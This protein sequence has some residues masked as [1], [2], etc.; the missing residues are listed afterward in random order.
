[1]FHKIKSIIYNAHKENI[2]RQEQLFCFAVYEY[3]LLSSSPP[4]EPG[5]IEHL[6]VE[7]EWTEL[8]H[9]KRC[10]RSIRLT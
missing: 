10:V 6:T 4:G 5:M 2:S 9:C 1:M 3:M 7:G 8:Y